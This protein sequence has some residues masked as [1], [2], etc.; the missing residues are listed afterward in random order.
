MDLGT[1]EVFTNPN[2]SIVLFR[3]AMGDGSGLDSE[4]LEVSFTLN[5]H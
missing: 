1:L 3:D 2:N 4:T 5:A